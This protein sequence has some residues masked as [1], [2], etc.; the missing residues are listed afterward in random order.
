MSHFQGI[1]VSPEVIRAASA[2][3]SCAHEAIYRAYQ[4]PVYTLVRRLVPRSA[5]ADELFQEVFVEILR[6]VKSYSGDGYFGGWVRSI[7][8]NKC[9]MYL[10]S[11]LHRSL[12]WLD[13]EEGEAGLP[14]DPTHEAGQIESR[15]DLERALATLAPLTRAIVWLHD[16]EGYTHVEIA[17]QLGRTVSFSKSQLARAHLRLRELLDPIDES[18]PCTPVSTS[19]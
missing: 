7:A 2:G 11:P 19:C 9:F 10:R 6:S 1:T 13:A 18:L 3:D 17:R 4:R 8:V 5:V 14:V 12:H 16:V 15:A